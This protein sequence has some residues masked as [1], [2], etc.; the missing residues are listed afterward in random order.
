MKFSHVL[1]DIELTNRCNALCSFC[2]RD[3]TPQQG[4]LS[5]EN[6]FSAI[7][8]VLELPAP[9]PKVTFTGQ[10][11][12]TLHADIVEFMHHATEKGLRVGMTSNA[13]KLHENLARDLVDAGLKEISLSISDFGDDY[14]EV[15]N[16]DFDNS[17]TNA[18]KFVEI[19]RDQVEITINIVEH[20]INKGKI[21]EMKAF[22]RE[23]G[24]KRFLVFSQNNRG[25]ACDNGKLFLES[26]SAT[27]EA[28]ELMSQHGI[29]SL[30]DA[31]FKFLF[32]GWSGHYYVCCNDYEKTTPLGHVSE[33]GFTEL[34]NTKLELLA[35]GGISA[36]NNC[37]LDPGNKV[38]EILLERDAGFATDDDVSSLLD[39]LRSDQQG[40][41]G[42]HEDLDWRERVLAQD[43]TLLARSG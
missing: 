20:D 18:L 16:L 14:E 41:P 32:V 35:R 17:M 28:Q 1:V 19:A 23:H 10:G 29:S 9:L 43:Q 3:K 31:A 13:S 11:E 22:W 24:V 37:D 38:R 21:E 5:R 6:F 33:L 36:C 39:T 26:R 30:C 12:P 8:R 40:F 15:Y 27:D 34:N 7:D 42:M 4:M 25:G 2:P